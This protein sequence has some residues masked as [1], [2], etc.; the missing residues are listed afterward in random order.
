MFCRQHQHRR[1]CNVK[2]SAC[3]NGSRYL[4]M[5]LRRSSARWCWKQRGALDILLDETDLD[6][7]ALC[8]LVRHCASW[9][10]APSF[11]AATKKPLDEETTA[12]SQEIPGHF[13]LQ[14]RVRKLLIRA[15]SHL[16]LSDGPTF[17]A[18]EAAFIYMQTLLQLLDWKA[19]SH[20]STKSTSQWLRLRALLSS[21]FETDG[22][23]T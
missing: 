11:S 8:S 12:A 3:N 21:S 16:D 4:A 7:D 15:L 20:L 13:N 22:W 5:P 23:G 10:R 17:Q 14:Q 19:R 1:F 9:L 18:L 6:G 2:S